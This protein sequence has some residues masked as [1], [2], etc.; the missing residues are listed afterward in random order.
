MEKKK[1]PSLADLGL[2]SPSVIPK[3]L[4][5]TEPRQTTP[6]EPPPNT[7][8][9]ASHICYFC[10]LPIEPNAIKCPH[11]FE[12]LD[13]QRAPQT[14]Y[15][16]KSKSGCWIPI[17]IFVVMVF[18]FGVLASIME[19]IRPPRQVDQWSQASQ[20]DADRKTYLRSEL[21]AY[22]GMLERNIFADAHCEGREAFVEVGPHYYTA[23]EAGQKVHRDTLRF[24]WIERMN[25]TQVKLMDNGRT[26][27]TIR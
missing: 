24:L 1:Q 10:K 13:K 2:D 8:E 7:E 22:N 21:N 9:P 16:Q 12:W 25:G 3:N 6:V 15:V 17:V 26:I 20:S 19:S 14:I 5:R 4:T 11:C 23:T 18:G 27:A